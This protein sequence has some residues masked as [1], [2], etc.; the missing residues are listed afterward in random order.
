MCTQAVGAERVLIIGDSLSKEYEV[1]WLG[2][3]GAPLVSPKP[4]WAEILDERRAQ[5]F[6]FGNSGVFGDWRLIGHDYNWSIPGSYARDWPG[7]LEDAPGEL[8]DQL[9]NVVDRVVIFLGGN[10]IRVKYQDL[11]S[12]KPSAEWV[13][14]VVSD[15]RAVVEF[16]QERNPALQVVLVNV[17]HLGASP[18]VNSSHPYDPG[19]TG[20]VTAALD[21]LNGRLAAL[22]RE[23]GTG[24]ANI[25]RI[26]RELVTK[27]YWVI[28]GYRS[29]KQS[30]SQGAPDCL[31]LG[32]GF[33][34]NYS[35][36][37][38]FAQIILDA[39]NDRYG[40]GIPRLGNREILV[41]ILSVGASQTMDQWVKGFGVGSGDRGFADDPDGDGVRNIL[42][43]AFDMDPTYPDAHRLPAPRVVPQSGGPALRL[44][45]QPRDPGGTDYARFV[46]E[47]SVDGIHWAAVPR[48]EVKSGDYNTRSLT[49]SL[50]DDGRLFLRYRITEVK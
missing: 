46:I 2:I 45:W 29:N 12:G 3:G 7:Y 26:T 39:F 32:D 15:I 21:D 23:R 36:Q 50:P 19:K 9:R 5:W 49:R 27:P 35:I 22:A 18:K 6:E 37:A 20:R 16:V 11:Y 28:G 41:N 34:P 40:T 30:S 14:Q 8:V 43:F 25:Y 10:D 42:E 13:A 47:E 33:H 31:F 38:V 24:I 44:E 4:N 1:E 17:P 48:S